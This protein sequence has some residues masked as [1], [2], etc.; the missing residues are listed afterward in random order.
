MALRPLCRLPFCALLLLPGM[1][2]ASA[3][4]TAGGDGRTLTWTEDDWSGGQYAATSGIDPEIEPGLLVLENRLD[5]LRFLSQPTD[6]QGLWSID[7]YRDTLFMTASDYPYMY[8]GA[9][10]IAFDYQADTYEIVY[11]P[12]ESGLHLIK[13]IGDTIYVPGPDSMDPWTDEGS[14]YVYDG[15]TW[16]E[17]ATLPTAIHVNDVEILDDWLYVTTAHATGDMNGWGCIWRSDDWGDTFELV[18]TIYPNPDK[19]YRRFFGLGKFDNML[20]AQPDGYDP[21]DE[22]LFTSTDGV[23]WDS[24]YVPNLPDELQCSFISWGDSLLMPVGTR[25]YIWNGVQWRNRGLPFNLSR[26]GRGIQKWN[27]ELIGGGQSC[28]IHRWLGESNWEPLGTLPAEV[29]SVNISDTATYFGR[30]FISTYRSPVGYPARLY[31]SA[32]EPIGTLESLP[33]DFETYTRNGVLSWDD[34]RPGE[35]NL[36]AFQ[37]RSAPS[38]AELAVEPYIGPDGTSESY[39]EVSGTE[40]PIDHYAD[41]YFQYRVEMRCPE[42]LWMPLLRSVTLEVDVCDPSAVEDVPAA[43]DAPRLVFHAP[44]PNPAQGGTLLRA[45][46]TPALLAARQGAEGQAVARVQVCDLLGR[47]V[48]EAAVPIDGSGQMAWRWDLRDDRGRAVAAG[49]YR[50]RIEVGGLRAA[51][52]GQSLVVLR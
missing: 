46:V 2:L 45:S 3:P 32:S 7:V 24:C 38:L 29:D 34:Y 39:Y 40:L 1:L 12:Y 36:A 22:M 48:R 31:V 25:M 37:I 18:H 49:I 17:K 26:W 44:Q 8:D 43:G 13:V 16:I 35:G 15:E 4:A 10:V 27:G 5:D 52:S 20:F 9:D 50:A 6:W 42:G 14:I 30:L 11:Q 41:R 23:Q 19:P 28:Q 47:R 51:P 21:E 33:Y